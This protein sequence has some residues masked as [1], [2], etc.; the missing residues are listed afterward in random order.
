VRVRRRQ[1]SA[2]ALVS[3]IRRYGTGGGRALS[4]S[5]NIELPQNATVSPSGVSNCH[6]WSGT[7]PRLIF[8]A[9]WSWSK[10]RK[11]E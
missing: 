11:V 5:A 2:E 7:P 3:R 1:P 10:A 4:R 9:N 8:S 6:G